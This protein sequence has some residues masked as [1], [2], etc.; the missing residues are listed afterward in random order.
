MGNNKEK[1]E[2]L[3]KNWFEILIAYPSFI[4]CIVIMGYLVYCGIG[5]GAENNKDVQATKEVASKYTAVLSEAKVEVVGSIEAENTDNMFMGSKIIIRDLEDGV[6]TNVSPESIYGVLRG[7]VNW[8][9]GDIKVVDKI[10][11][12]DTDT[13]KE[14]YRAYASKGKGQ[15]IIDEY[16]KE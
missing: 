1:V 9:I 12:V 16:T 2:K 14:M 4:F 8:S 6:E 7:S 13:G 11:Y 15:R 10:S 5:L 3:K